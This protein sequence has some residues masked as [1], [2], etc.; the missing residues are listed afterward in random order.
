MRSRI[1]GAETDEALL[2]RY[3]AH[4]DD[5]A[6]RDEL[7]ARHLPLARALARGYKTTSEPVDDLEQVAALGLMKALD[8][9]DPTRGSPFR[10]Y[11]IP[12]IRG[13]LRRHFRDTTWAVRPSRSVQ[14]LAGRVAKARDALS[15]RLG[16][17]PTPADI[18]DHLGCQTEQVLEAYSA[19]L[20]YRALSFDADGTNDQELPLVERV[21]QVDRHYELVE[22]ALSVGPALDRLPSRDRDVITLR[23]EHDLTQSEIAERVG[24]SQMHVSRILRASLS[25]VRA[26]VERDASTEASLAA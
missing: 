18:A 22:D 7:V 11:A 2:R 14:E 5:L 21:G 25:R 9:F 19:L 24:L 3:H 15:A 8:R 17:S 4:H 26:V 13:E 16:R 12:T 1:A 20:D 23:F 6:A 10:A